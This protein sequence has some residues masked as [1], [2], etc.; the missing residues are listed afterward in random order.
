MQ[1]N[2]HPS[3]EEPGH[4]SRKQ[5][6]LSP[7]LDILAIVPRRLANGL[8]F[9]SRVTLTLAVTSVLIAGCEPTEN[10]IDDNGAIVGSVQLEIDYRSDRDKLTLKVPCTSDST[11]LS[12]LQ[13]AKK[14]GDLEFVSTGRAET[15]FVRSIS[16]VENQAAEGDNWVYRV[17]GD[18]GDRS[19]GKFSVKPDDHVL[20]VFG[21]Y[22]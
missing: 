3:S 2:Q 10:P 22:P 7:A 9:V 1:I 19:C 21:K 15:A 4:V 14:S 12:V 6:C 18:L 20:W 17:N 13:Q 16:G 5:R 11:V 8:S